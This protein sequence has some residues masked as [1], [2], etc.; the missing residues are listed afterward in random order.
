MRY[1]DAQT[2]ML[3]P[4]LE[5]ESLQGKGDGLLITQTDIKR[6]QTPF[7]DESE[8]RERLSVIRG[9]Y[10]AAD[11]LL[12]F[13]QSP[14]L[15][16]DPEP[17]TLASD[18]E[19]YPDAIRLV[20]EKQDASLTCLK[21]LGCSTNRATAMLKAMDQDK[22][23]SKAGKT[24]KRQVCLTPLNLEKFLSGQSFPLT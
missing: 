16:E 6:I 19:L 4:P 20:V 9:S 11:N 18:D 7:I 3:K 15:A 8:L 22:V 21:S 1:S 23:T 5:V 2:L 14:E 12:S 13:D 10:P 17:F 24:G